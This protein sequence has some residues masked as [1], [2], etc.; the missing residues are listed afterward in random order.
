MMYI[1]ELAKRT[2]TTRKAIH[3]YETLGLI[4]VPQRK[5]RYRIYNEADA[6]LICMIKRAKSLGF[7]L[8]EIIDVVSVR[9]KTQKLPVEMVVALIDL[10]RKNLRDT[11]NNAILQDRQLAELQAELLGKS[12]ESS[13]D[14]LPELY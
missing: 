8:K 10:K 14:S 11:V 13:M 2:G 1:G 12:V 5:G 3:H 4:P 6:N 9:A 7:S